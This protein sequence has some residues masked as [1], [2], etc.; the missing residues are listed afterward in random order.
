MKIVFL[1]PSLRAGGAE[2]VF[3]NLLALW[4]QN[5]E[6]HLV[7]LRR[8]GV[9]FDLVPPRVTIHDLRGRRFL[10]ALPRLLKLL[11]SLNPDTV[12]GTQAH[13]NVALGLLRPWIR[14]P[15]VIGRET[16]MPV[17]THGAKGSSPLRKAL[18]GLGYRGLDR[19]ICSS[20]AMA[21]EARV[22]YRLDP[23]RVVVVPNPLIA[24]PRPQPQTLD[25][26][27]TWLVAVGRLENNKGFDLLLEAL[28]SL[29]TS[30]HVVIVGDGSLREALAHQAK[31]L[32]VSDRVVFAG[33]QKEPG[34][35]VAA[36]RAFV[37]S[38]RYE[39][40]PNAALEALALGVPV[41]AFDGPWGAREVIV[42][43]VTGFLARPGDSIDLARAIASVLDH[44][45]DA[46]GLAAW[47]RDRYDGSTI[48]ARYRE[49]LM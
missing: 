37:L 5:D 11:R 30:I 25:P 2:R 48:Q 41:A 10:L 42:E 13:I 35:W 28:P 33:F 36:A 14:A 23:A 21:E 26:R 7:L 4:N 6:L 8:E 27:W 40:L 12:L 47:A 22:F 34:R 17:Q 20:L 44:Q 32:G 43:G 24:G 29:P 15:R 16:N 31:D 39:G 19:L 45:W 38:S 1:I 46:T 3:A 49:V 9:Y 18:Y